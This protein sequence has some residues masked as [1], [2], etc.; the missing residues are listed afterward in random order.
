MVRFP[1]L[2][3]DSNSFPRDNARVYQQ[4]RNQVDY[5][6]YTGETIL[7]PCNVRWTLS[8]KDRVVFEDENTR[9]QYFQKLEGEVY[10]L[11]TRIDITPEDKVKLPI[12]YNAIQG[13]NYLYAQIPEL[14]NADSPLDYEKAGVKHYFYFIEDVHY[15]APSTTECTLV[16]D[17]FTTWLN[18]LTISR[19]MLAR[20]HLPFTY[21]SVSD[22]LANPIENTIGLTQDE[23]EAPPAPTKVAKNIFSPLGKG[24]LWAVLA[25]KCSPAQASNVTSISAGSDSDAS[26]SDYT[27]SGGD[28]TYDGEDYVVNGYEWGAL[29][30]L[31]NQ[32]IGTDSGYS[33]DKIRPNGYGITAVAA[34]D[35]NTMMNNLNSSYQPLW[36]CLEAVY[37]VPEDFISFG[38]S[39]EIAGVTNYY[40]SSAGKT[41]LMNISLTP[42]DFGYEEKYKEITK[43]YTT[44]Y[45]WLSISD[46]QGRETSIR[47][48]D[49]SNNLQVSRQVSL[50][51]PYINARTFL[52]GIG[53]GADVSYSWKGINGQDITTDIP[54]A[55]FIQALIEHEIPTYSI[56]A[57]NAAVWN[58]NNNSSAIYNARQNA[59]NAYHITTRGANTAQYNT[60]QS[61]ATSVANTNRSNTATTNSTARSNTL[62][63]QL[64]NN[65]TA[66]LNN[67]NNLNYDKINNDWQVQSNYNAEM[68]RYANDLTIARSDIQSESLTAQSNISNGSSL[69]NGAISGAMGGGTIG[70]IGGVAGA[71]AGAAVGAIG[72]L[73]T[74]A[75]NVGFSNLSVNAAITSN[76]DTADA[77]TFNNSQNL[78]AWTRLAGNT[79]TYQQNYNTDVKNLN[80]NL[81]NQN[82]SAS[83]SAA[84]DITAYGVNASNSNA[85]ASASTSNS[86]AGRTRHHQVLSGQTNLTQAQRGYQ[87]QVRDLRRSSNQLVASASG[88]ATLDL[89]G[90]RG[91]QIRVMTQNKDI[92]RKTGD[93]FLRYGY[94]TNENVENPNLLP[95]SKFSYWQGEPMIYGKA[96][97]SSVRIITELFQDGVTLWRDPEEIG[98]SI[99]ENEVI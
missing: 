26:Y 45:A 17:D 23:P 15:L 77:I 72:G 62:N 51:Y 69:V 18:Q 55:G 93:M 14:Q 42:D 38:N 22:Y 71:A 81:A 3:N 40:V 84:T 24:D 13:C 6:N 99:Y 52:E 2:D 74:A 60:E 47:I 88:D 19:I 21:T 32:R 33:M 9:N 54:A 56:F 29:P 7:K 70:A 16:L 41:S 28:M 49:T 85:S 43:L 76:S 66:F 20:G 86:N 30:N 36:N 10:N 65:Q 8:S 61:N 44:P 34:S 37:M 64:T 97:A 58:A 35:L 48:E 75:I 57:S 4:Y 98:A 68:T 79:V 31:N 92:T 90:N 89:W 87:A 63:T 11:S 1:H 96:P 83:N 73:A 12:P 46:G 25:W 67:M 50:I 27:N 91:I 53:G 59:I 39:I 80:V 82:V 94:S 5:D 78:G 95:M